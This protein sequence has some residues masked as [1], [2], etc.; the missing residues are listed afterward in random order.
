[1][2]DEGEY[3]PGSIFRVGA[4]TPPAEMQRA[5]QKMCAHV[6]DQEMNRVR[7]TLTGRLLA[8]SV[9]CLGVAVG[10]LILDQHLLLFALP[11]PV[12]LLLIFLPIYSSL[13][14]RRVRLQIVETEPPP[15]EPRH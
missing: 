1:M 5:V 11:I 3:I 7:R 12:A 10:G 8:V 14:E 4:T 9:M 13:S 15:N 2:G 6:V